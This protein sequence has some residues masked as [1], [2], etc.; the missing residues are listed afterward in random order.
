MVVTGE[1]LQL[2]TGKG[3]SGKSALSAALAIAASEEGAK[4][5]AI[6]M[7]ATGGLPHH[8]G[9]GDVGFEPT[10]ITSRLHVCSIDRAAALSE[11][12]R[13]QM[14]V[15]RAATVGPITRIFDALAATAPAIREIVTLGKVLWEVKRGDWDLVV[16]DAPPTGQ[17]PGY[18]R[19][20]RTIAELVERGRIRG[21]A[22]W[23]DEILTDGRARSR[24]FV[25]SLLEELP[26]TE[27]CELMTWLDDEFPLIYRT[28]V[29]NRVLDALPPKP[30]TGHAATDQAAQLH[31][32]VATE[33]SDWN[34]VLN[35]DHEL[36]W[37][38]GASEPESVVRRFVKEV[39][40]W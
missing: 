34:K 35:P 40:A 23:M 3:G 20:P 33:Q 7:A 6:D 39:G 32:S 29:A 37:V 10:Q 27:T 4:V 11:Y 25:V 14:S 31:R 26:V 21:Q 19:A 2:V 36:P 30:P 12:L 9:V 1:K 18:L 15:P 38:F 17:I 16:A 24:L 28:I 13:V 5:L 22:D 8:L